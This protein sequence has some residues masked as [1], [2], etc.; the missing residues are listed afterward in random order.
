MSIVNVSVNLSSPTASG[1]IVDVPQFDAY[2]HVISN[3]GGFGGP[4]ISFTDHAT[5]FEQWLEVI[6]YDIVALNPGLSEVNAG[7]VNEVTIKIGSLTV[8]RGP[9]DR[10]W[11]TR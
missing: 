4:T 2:S 8:H 6:G 5:S 3:D 1:V 9:L 10:D 7:F 11:E